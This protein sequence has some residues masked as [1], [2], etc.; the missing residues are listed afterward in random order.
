MAR[1]ASQTFVPLPQLTAQALA[2]A[3]V[4]LA[5]TD[6]GVIAPGLDEQ[7]NA[8]A[9]FAAEEI[10]AV[11]RNAAQLTMP[12]VRATLEPADEEGLRLAVHVPR[13]VDLHALADGRV[14]VRSGA[15]NRA[16]GGDEIRHLAAT[17]ASGDF[18]AEPVPGATLDD[19][20][21]AIVAE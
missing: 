3:L 1:A 17:K 12:P 19:L 16:L 6:G 4:A 11:L 18:E 20:D 14:L 5:N 7:G 10:E 21:D 8:V 13:S 2:E 9:Q 15:E